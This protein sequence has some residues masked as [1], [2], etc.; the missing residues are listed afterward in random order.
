MKLPIKLFCGFILFFLQRIELYSLETNY[1]S[2][3]NIETLETEESRIPNRYLKTMET[4]KPEILSFARRYDAVFFIAIPATYYI[5]FNLIQQKNWYF[6]NTYSLDT[7]DETFLYLSTLFL[8]LFVA[9]V[10][11]LYT[12]DYNKKVFIS[13][14][15]LN[16]YSSHYFYSGSKEFYFFL[17]IYNICF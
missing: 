1:S 17:P 9:Y 4:N 2:V 14:S 13:T 11:Y 15:V 7:A 3:T 12:E 10:D 8:P 16:N 5:M 6:K